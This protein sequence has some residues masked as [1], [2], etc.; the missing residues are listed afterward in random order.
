MRPL[1]VQLAKANKLTSL[2][3]LYPLSLV[4]LSLTPRMLDHACRR[5]FPAKRLAPIPVVFSRFKEP[6]KKPVKSTVSSLLSLSLICL[7]TVLA[8]V[9]V[10]PSKT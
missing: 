2:S 1:R 4:C 8:R 3:Q 10:N 9:G 5:V 7:Y 6:P